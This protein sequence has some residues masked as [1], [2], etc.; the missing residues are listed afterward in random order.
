MLRHSNELKADISIAT[1]ENYVTTIKAVEPEISIATEKFYVT[2]E[3]RREV[4]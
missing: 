3:N 1:K 4:R 2:T